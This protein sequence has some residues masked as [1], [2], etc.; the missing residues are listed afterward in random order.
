LLQHPAAPE[1]LLANWLFGSLNYFGQDAAMLFESI[2]D[3]GNRRN[4]FLAER[5]R[6][7]IEAAKT[8]FV[9]AATAAPRRKGGIELLRC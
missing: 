8:G 9:N 4:L 5:Q 1:S 3:H 7:R 2:I 6:I